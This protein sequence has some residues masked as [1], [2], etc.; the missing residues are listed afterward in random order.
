MT[1]KVEQN[2]ILMFERNLV[3]LNSV[4]ELSVESIRQ[5]LNRDG[6]ACIRGIIH[7]TEIIIARQHLTQWC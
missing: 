7:E 2:K 4:E 6:L 5:S 3:S 1:T